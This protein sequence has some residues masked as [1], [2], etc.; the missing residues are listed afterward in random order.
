ME[1]EVVRESHAF[2]KARANGVVNDEHAR[3]DSSQCCI[4]SLLMR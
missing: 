2:E 1:N 4:R 3:Y